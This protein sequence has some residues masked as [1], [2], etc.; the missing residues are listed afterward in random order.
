MRYAYKIWSKSLKE[1]DYLEDPDVDGRVILRC[2]VEKLGGN[3]WTGFSFHKNGGF[4]D[5]L[6]DYQLL[7]K[8]SVSKSKCMSELLSALQMQTLF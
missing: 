2:I 3:V 5:Q 8:G 7:M 4:P 6:S 1:R